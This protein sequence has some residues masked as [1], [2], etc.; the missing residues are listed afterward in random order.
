MRAKIL[1]GRSSPAPLQAHR[2]ARKTQ[3][4]KGTMKIITKTL[5][6][7]S[8]VSMMG[9]ATAPAQLNTIINFDEFGNGDADGAPLPANSMFEP[10]SGLTTLEYDLPFPG[11]AGDL[12]IIEPGGP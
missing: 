3:I 8:I 6:V 1:Y 12:F 4:K 7:F 9:A 11:V 10:I 2:A 5:L